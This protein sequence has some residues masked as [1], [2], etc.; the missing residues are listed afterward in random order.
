MSMENAADR[1]IGLA[2]DDVAAE[3]LPAGLGD[4]IRAAGAVP[5]GP[6]RLDDAALP[7]WR[8]ARLD[9]AILAL[10]GPGGAGARLVASLHHRG[11]P[12]VAVADPAVAQALARTFPTVPVFSHPTEAADLVEALREQVEGWTGA[13][14]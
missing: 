1:V 4:A 3:L 6:D 9:G 2:A 12:V 11:A 8:A 14:S 7:E 13:G 5:R 10:A